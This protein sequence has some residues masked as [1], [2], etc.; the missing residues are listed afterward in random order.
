M[1][2]EE[3]FFDLLKSP[4]HWLFE[5]FLMAV[6]DGIIGALLWPFVRKHWAHHLD[7]DRKEG[8]SK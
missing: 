8:L 3:T 2:Y 1:I 5:L 6:F 4:G 7:R